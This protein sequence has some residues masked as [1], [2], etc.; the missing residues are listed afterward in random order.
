MIFYLGLSAITSQAGETVQLSCS[1][2]RVERSFA[3]SQVGWQAWEKSLYFEMAQL[4][5]SL[6]TEDRF[7]ENAA[8]LLF[9]SLAERI[10]KPNRYYRTIPQIRTISPWRVP[11]SLEG[12]VEPHRW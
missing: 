2:A 7:T 11:P 4:S 6:I 1:P 8:V 9:A 3:L 5:Y 12:G 10:G